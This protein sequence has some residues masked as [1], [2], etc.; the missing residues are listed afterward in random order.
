MMRGYGVFAL[1]LAVRTPAGTT[2]SI[3]SSL[4]VYNH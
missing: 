4:K 2:Y 1:V 3:G